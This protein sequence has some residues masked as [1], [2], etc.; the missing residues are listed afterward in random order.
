M[1]NLFNSYR[2]QKILFII[3]FPIVI[4]L[5][6]FQILIFNGNFYNK[7]Y[8]KS[9]SYQN[10]ER[11]NIVQ[12]ATLNLLGYFRGQNQ[13]DV[14]FYSNQAAFHLKDV[15]NLLGFTRGLFILTTILCLTIIFRFIFTRNYLE[16]L[17]ALFSGALVTVIFII[18]AGAGLL[19]AFN[20]LFIKFHQLL[21][22]NDL[23]L[24]D[25]TD[26]LIKLFPE[27]FFI[28]FANQLALNIFLTSALIAI[29]SCILEF[30]LKT[31]SYKS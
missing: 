23:W 1:K 25:E 24:F 27:Q 10:F 26:N 8:E 12:N 20:W 16:L 2:V 22:T 9:G 4:I 14:N 17:N 18:L 21:F 11:E 7:L 3:L 30:R 5:G 31:T 6:N 15:K 13:L 28:N 29:I 19:T